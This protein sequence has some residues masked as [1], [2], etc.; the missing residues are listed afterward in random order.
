MSDR[1]ALTRRQWLSTGLAATAGLAGLAGCLAAGNGDSG[2]EEGSDGEGDA[3]G[4][5][6]AATPGESDAA[7]ESSAPN[8]ATES[9]T[10]LE[11][12]L[13]DE[14]LYT[15]DLDD[16]EGTVVLEV[17]SAD[18]EP[19][20]EGRVMVAADS[21]R[22]DTPQVAEVGSGTDAFGDD[23]DLADNQV[24]FGFT[25]EAGENHSVSLRGDQNQGTLD[26]EILPPSD[27]D[28][29]DAL[30]NSQ[31]VVIDGTADG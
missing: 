2:D 26:V 17:V 11:S 22:L 28:Y 21:A 6:E 7:G 18:G 10:E 20:S 25:G 29:T 3:D 16:G 4:G 9:L 30:E 15:D 24:G 13:Q 31:I 8:D 5:S 27:S 1:N 14:I 23:G 12:H 19:V